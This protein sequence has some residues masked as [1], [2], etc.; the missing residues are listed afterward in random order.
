MPVAGVVAGGGAVVSELVLAGVVPPELVLAGA[1]IASDFAGL[2]EGV[3][4]DVVLVVAG[5]VAAVPVVGVVDVPG[6][7]VPS[8]LSAVGM[9]A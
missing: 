2:L 6:L 5:V 1:V 4:F 3:L 7:A 8:I 9:L